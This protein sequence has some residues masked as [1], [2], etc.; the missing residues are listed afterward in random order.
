MLTVSWQNSPPQAA[1]RSDGP[2]RHLIWPSLTAGG[3]NQ[4]TKRQV[5]SCFLRAVAGE[6]PRIFRRRLPRFPG[7][8]RESI[9][10][11]GYS[12]FK[13]HR[14]YLKPLHYISR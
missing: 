3:Q 2:A 9:S 7:P 5:I 8:V 12:V 11:T 10:K 13:L 4:R 14:G 1:F 6:S